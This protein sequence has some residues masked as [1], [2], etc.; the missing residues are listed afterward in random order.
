[1]ATLV[2]D[3]HASIIRLRESG[4]EEKQV[5]LEISELKADIL[6]WMITLLIAQA[7]ATMALMK[8]SS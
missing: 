2:F 1:M 3:T 7:G 5:K 4:F 8:F 6:K